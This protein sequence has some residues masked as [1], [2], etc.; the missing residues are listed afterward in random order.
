MIYRLFMAITF[1]TAPAFGQEKP[2]DSDSQAYKQ[3][4]ELLFDSQARAKRAE[5]LLLDDGKKELATLSEKELSLLCRAYNEL[6]QSEKQLKVSKAIWTRFPESPE[7]TR[8]IVNSLLNTMRDDDDAAKT[9]AFVDS[10]LADKKGLRSEL[11]VLKAR[12]ILHGKKKISDA[13]R[14]VLVS[15]ILIDAFACHK[16]DDDQSQ[17]PDLENVNFVDMDHSFSQ[18]FSSVEREALKVR[19]RKARDSNK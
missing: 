13:E 19:M 16:K 15:D 14:R 18:Y 12:A 6:G 11:L 2:V 10:A 1:L 4:Y 5:A 8:W 7:S 9:I 17:F 3:A